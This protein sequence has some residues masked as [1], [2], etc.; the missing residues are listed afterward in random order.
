MSADDLE[1]ATRFL[2]TLALAARTGDRDALYPFL[3][4]DVEWEMPQ[5]GLRGIDDVRAHLT[6]ISPPE[7]LEIEFGE[8]EVTDH[9]DGR[10][11]SYV[12]ETYRM[13][14]TGEFAYA[15]GRRV[16]LT[17]RDRMIVRYEMTD[18][19]SDGQAR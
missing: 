12:E 9:G 4:A 14:G 8:P 18:V 19:S 11:V 17:I 6:W 13:K 7:K 5:R 15:R 2:E 10:I 1:V 3:A 16:E